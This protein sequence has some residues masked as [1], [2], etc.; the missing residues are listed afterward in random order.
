MSSTCMAHDIVTASSMQLTSPA[1]T[2]GLCSGLCW[3]T[4]ACG[5][6]LSGLCVILSRRMTRVIPRR[7]ITNNTCKVAMSH[8]R[9]MSSTCMAHVT[10]P[11]MQL[12]CYASRN[13][14]YSTHMAHARHIKNG[15]CTG[16]HAR[17]SGIIAIYAL[18]LTSSSLA[19]HSFSYFCHGCR[20]TSTLWY[21]IMRLQC[22]APSR[23]NLETKTRE[24]DLASC[25]LACPETAILIRR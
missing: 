6:G 15:T 8:S 9:H 14:W 12:P 10:A 13:Y 19:A 17:Q 20:S 5:L 23:V 16:P 2:N 18:I 1:S 7:P 22:A 11:S 3:R 25:W 4:Q 24:R 21:F